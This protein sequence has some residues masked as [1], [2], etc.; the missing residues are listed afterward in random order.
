MES[1]NRR[2]KKMNKRGQVIEL[3][4]GTVVGVVIFLFIVFAL[5]FGIA[6]LNPSGFFSAGSASAN[7]TTALTDNTTTLISNFSNR[8]PVVGTILGV[9]MILAIL[10]V[11]IAIILRYRGAGGT[12]NL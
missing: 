10:G 8:L 1:I 2:F 11:L 5:L 12:G 3:A 4:T 6:A 7:A 9:V